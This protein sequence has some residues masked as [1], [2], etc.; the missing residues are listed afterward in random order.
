[1]GGAG[2]GRFKPGQSGNPNG[3]P[4]GAA[5]LAKYIKEQT[6]EGKELADFWLDLFKGNV[7]NPICGEMSLK[8]LERYI[9]HRKDAARW[10]A[11]RGFGQAAQILVEDNDALNDIEPDELEFLLSLSEEEAKEYIAHEEAIQKMKDAK[12]KKDGDS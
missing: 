4:K 5:G 10:L 6:G 12:K 9:E 11:D 7:E 8:A 1:M 2:S 3:R